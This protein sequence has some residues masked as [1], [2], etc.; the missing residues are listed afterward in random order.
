MPPLSFLAP[1]WFYQGPRDGL[2]ASFAVTVGVSALAWSRF[3]FVPQYGHRN[4]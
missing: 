3:L 1:Q 4:R 2:G